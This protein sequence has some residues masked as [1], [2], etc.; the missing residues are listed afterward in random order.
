VL[1]AQAA[2]LPHKSDS[3]GVALNISDANS[4]RTAWTR[5]HSDIAR[6]K[7]GLVLDGILVEPMAKRG[8]ELIVGARNDPD[9]GPVLLVGLGGIWAE[10]LKD[11][12]LI[13]PELS[14][15]EIVD[16]L[17]KLKGSVLLRGFRG[18]PALDIEAAADVVFRLATLMKTAPQIA[19]VDVNPLVVYPAG[20][21][22]IA[23]DALIV[24]Q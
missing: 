1:K 14:R 12:R 20:E 5:M 24:T 18:S 10:A 21:G 19:E 17:N 4:M 3:G 16:Q 15:S 2:D 22:A 23:L 7:P 8:T 9:W 11:V 13:P 6:A